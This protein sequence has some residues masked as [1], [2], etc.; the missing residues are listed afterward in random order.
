MRGEREPRSLPG[1]H[2][3]DRNPSNDWLGVVRGVSTI[4]DGDSGGR[5]GGEEAYD[6]ERNNV[7]PKRAFI[8]RTA[9]N[10]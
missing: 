10:F 1:A 9:G 6:I 8:N 7:S 3:T 2:R 4:T 5:E